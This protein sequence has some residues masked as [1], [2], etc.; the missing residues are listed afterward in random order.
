[1]LT[2]ATSSDGHLDGG[3]GAAISSAQ[4]SATL[5][6]MISSGHIVGH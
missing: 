6:E 5:T 3:S 2:N 1:V 4:L